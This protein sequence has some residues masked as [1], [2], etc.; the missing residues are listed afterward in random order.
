[1]LVRVVGLVVALLCVGGAANAAAPAS[2]CK[3]A[4]TAQVK[5]AFGGT[6]GAGKVDT[7]LP[8][9]P[10]CHFKV[11]HSNLGRSG[12]AVVFVTPGQSAATFKLAKKYV[13]GAVT[14]P[15]VGTAA[16]YNPHTTS[17]ELLKGN[18]VA[19]AQGIFLGA[20][21]AKV[22]ADVIVLAKAVAKN[23]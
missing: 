12:E 2:P 20:D 21:A 10:T 8:S 16:F 13:P 19:S 3:L 23:L 22:K 5:A 11:T 4:T 15:G 1:M 14:V 6:V 7:S 17:I 9:A 18:A